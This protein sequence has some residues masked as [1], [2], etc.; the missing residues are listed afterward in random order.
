MAT[1]KKCRIIQIEIKITLLEIRYRTQLV[2]NY[3]LT[4]GPIYTWRR[5]CQRILNEVSTNSQRI[6]NKEF[7][8]AC[9]E[10]F[11][12]DEFLKNEILG[13]QTYEVKKGSFAKK[14]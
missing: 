12:V 9:E 11:F 8:F 6:L 4:L 1:L 2:I 14:Y 7:F 5:I 10:F 13:K 3:F